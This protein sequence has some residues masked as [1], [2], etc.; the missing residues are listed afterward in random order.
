SSNN[1]GLIPNPVV[2]YTS[3]N[4]TGS[5]SYAPLADQYG[6]AVIT[7]IVTDDGGT[8]NGGVNTTT[9]TFAI[10]VTPVNDAPTLNTI[11]NPSAIPQSSGIQTVNLSGITAGPNET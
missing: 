3:A 8:L 4:T 5:L 2:D 7:V 6:T 9:R 1:T 11:A 10:T